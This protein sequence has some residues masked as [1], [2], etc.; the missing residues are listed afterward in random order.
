[1]DFGERF[2]GQQTWG[3]TPS[4]S[5]WWVTGT[6]SLENLSRITVLEGTITLQI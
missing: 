1:M 6:G 4:A 3:W 2:C 5:L